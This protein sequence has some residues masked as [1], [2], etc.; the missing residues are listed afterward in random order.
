MNKTPALELW[1]T[2]CE[3]QKIVEQA[4]PLFSTNENLEVHTR[5][6]G[7]KSTRRVLCRHP[8]MEQLIIR[9]VEILQHDWDN[10]NNEFDG[11]L[12]IMFRKIDNFV[13]PLYIGKAETF[14]KKAK[15]FSVNLIKVQTDRSKFARWGDG[16]EYH[17]GDLS[18]AVLRDHS[19]EKII[20]KYV[21]WAN[22]LFENAP[23]DNPKLR[24]TVY[25]WT[26]AWKPSDRGIW[27]E[28]HPMRLSFLEYLLIGVAS[29]AFGD[30][31]LNS[32]GRNR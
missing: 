24:T 20:P 22:S 15:N 27:A 32:E 7:S 19:A 18:A 6:V 3:A 1:E 12:Y 21:K 25:F 14:G 10:H 17:I 30:D 26:K 8:E 9:N 16:Y 23:A 2:W 13:V 31:F 4:V 5:T 29:T 28:M 11:I